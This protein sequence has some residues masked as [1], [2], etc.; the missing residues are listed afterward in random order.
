MKQDPWAG[1][2]LR[3]RNEAGTTSG[4][5]QTSSR[6]LNIYIYILYIYRCVVCQYI[7]GC[8]ASLNKTKGV[9]RDLGVMIGAWYYQHIL[10]QQTISSCEFRFRPSHAGCAGKLCCL[11]HCN[12]SGMFAFQSIHAINVVCL[13]WLKNGFD[14][15]S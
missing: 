15:A 6:N 11:C 8:F 4:N 14:L 9:A 10:I 2:P 13:L 7:S 1:N 12:F 3:L 5:Y